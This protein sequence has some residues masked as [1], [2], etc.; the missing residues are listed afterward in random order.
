[1]EYKYDKIR[2]LELLEQEKSLN[3]NGLS[4]YTE[5]RDKYLELL[6]YQVQ[7]ADNRSWKN[8][9]KY[10]S[11]MNN[12]VNGKITAEDFNDDFLYLW[13]KDRDT[14]DNDYEPNI[15]SKGFGKFINKVFFLREDFEP[16]ADE[17]E[18]YNE[19]WLKDSVSNVLIQI[20]KEYNSN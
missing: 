20:Q 13:R 15:R 9:K 11:V 10:F 5:D 7:L 14:L 19:K 17:N 1:M 2:Y 8:R 3:K 12:F 6:N 16:E 18:E 4:L